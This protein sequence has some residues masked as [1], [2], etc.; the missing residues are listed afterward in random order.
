MMKIV[1]FVSSL[2]K[3]FAF[4]IFGFLFWCYLNK[5]IIF[6]TLWI[7]YYTNTFHKRDS[8]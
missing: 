3:V 6:S 7:A 1:Y 4:I 5:I 2:N 8:P